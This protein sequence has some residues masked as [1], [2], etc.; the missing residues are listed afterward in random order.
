M[1]TARDLSEAFTRFLSRKRKQRRSWPVPEDAKLILNLH[2]VT[3]SP[4][5]GV[6]HAEAQLEIPTSIGSDF[7]SVTASAKNRYD[8]LI[9]VL[10]RIEQSNWFAVF[11]AEKTYF[12]ITG[13]E[14]EDLYHGY[15]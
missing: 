5:R 8:A 4:H 12:K 1:P 10:E 15:I 13:C 11:K 2:F 9:L 3:T 7:Y 14:F 6:H